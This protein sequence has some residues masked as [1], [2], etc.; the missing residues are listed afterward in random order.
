MSDS[1][2]SDEW[3][4]DELVIPL[5]SNAAQEQSREAENDDGDVDWDVSIEKKKVPIADSNSP[6]V[7]QTSGEPMIIVDITLLDKSVHCK[8]DRNSVNDA[9]AASAWRKRI[10]E[11]FEK[12]AKDKELLENGTVIPCG[13]SVWRDALVR[14]RDERNGHYFCP[15]FPKKS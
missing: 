13:S 14:L 12:Y 11:S 2:D 8:F 1:D 4:V 5:Q 10:E 9:N 7:P 15:V 6:S 3:A